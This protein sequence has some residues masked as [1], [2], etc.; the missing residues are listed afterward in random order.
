MS[1]ITRPYELNDTQFTNSE[2]GV[3]RS[4]STFE[5]ALLDTHDSTSKTKTCFGMS[6]LKFCCACTFF[7]LALW[8]PLILCVIIPAIMQS[9]VNHADLTISA[10]TIVNPTTA[11]FQAVNVQT[12]TNAGS[13]TA[14]A[15][16]NHLNINWNTPT[17]GQLVQL[18]KS[19]EFEVKNNH[20]VSMTSTATVENE[21]AFTNFNSAAI[22][23][24]S[25]TWQLSGDVDVT[26]VVTAK[27]NLDKTVT[28]QGFDNF[29]IPPNVTCVNTTGGTAA[30]LH[31]LITATMTSTSD[32]S[33]Q[34]GQTMHFLLKSAGITV[35]VGSIPNYDM[36]SGTS[37]VNA[38]VAL[39]YSSTEE[40]TQLMRVLSNYS[41][42]MTSPVTM[43]NFYTE[44]TIDWLAPALNSISMDTI[45]PGATASFVI[46]VTMFEPVDPERGVD[47]TMLLYNPIDTDTTIT[48]IAGDFSYQGVVFGTIDTD[49]YIYLPTHKRTMSPKLTAE[50]APGAAAIKAYADLVSFVWI[51]LA[52]DDIADF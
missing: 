13:I 11:S 18:G 23:G 42:G 22:N 31:N 38:D 45:M 33:I 37:V 5:T 10:V 50:P 3:P 46:N 17:G 20:Q 7:N 26:F 2:V 47:F 35:G 34:F 44:T 49:T 21:D 12:F 19:N 51:V 25:M 32:I 28:I 14:T 36:V 9:L 43:S 4:G 16:T 40:K 29:P 6:R 24:S 41:N 27:C 1:A 48:H 39:S 15:Y 52:R 8:V 30:V